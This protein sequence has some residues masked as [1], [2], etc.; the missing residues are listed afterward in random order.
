MEEKLSLSQRFWQL[1][2]IDAKEIRNVYYYSFF[3]G[4]TSLTLPLGIQAIINLIQIGRIN[5]AWIVMVIIVVLGFAV[6]GI[7]QIL[8][9]RITENIQQRIFTRAAFDFAYRVPRIKLEALFKTY[10]PELVNRFFDVVT[11]QKGMSK[12]LT[13]ISTSGVTVFL[14]LILLSLY[15]PFFIIFSFL[16]IVILYL[17]FKLMGKRGLLTSFE[18]STHKYK[19]VHWLEEVGRTSISF[20]MAGKTDYALERSNIHADDYLEAREKHFK[21]LVSHYSLLVI[22]KVLIVAGLLIIGGVLVMEQ[23]MNIGQ[24]VAAEIIIVMIIN[25]IEK[26]IRDI[27][28][29]YD[30]LTGI[31]K[32][33]QVTDLPL[34]NNEGLDL[35]LN[36][37]EGGLN[38]S[39]NDLSFMYPSTAIKT[40]SN[41]KLKVKSN[42]SVAIVGKISSG[43]STLMQ[44]IAGFYDVK[45]GNISYND[46]SLGSLNLETLRNVIG[47][48]LIQED[49]F[50]GTIIEN[51]KVGR[52][53]A[54]TQNVR[55]AIEKVGLTD[56][57][58][59]LPMGFN[60]MIL[61]NGQ[62]LPKNV[63]QKL[64]IARSIVDKPRLLLLEN[65]FERVTPE[66]KKTIMDFLFDKKN[67]WTIIFIT[68]DP[69]VMT[70]C[71][72]VVVMDKGT[73]K[74]Q[75]KYDQ[76]KH[77]LNDN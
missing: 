55:W 5:S 13:S 52:S 12:L 24:F 64:L 50:Y 20:R 53:D 16:L 39:I 46:L 56:F 54:S 45:Q 77:L 73:I 1:I 72:K 15:H 21:V 43:K 42:E 17:M 44:I 32:V 31:E 8:Q 40:L 19:L 35:G 11:I 25:S 37:A 4:L 67:N 47:T 60:T 41:V 48:N 51:I 6:K 22:F 63:V 9:L 28:T 34:E 74:Q 71:D 68:K 69:E 26:L 30:V 7:L 75:G 57:I 18:E 65:S 2:K 27:D 61:P 29:I 62:S 70:I 3:A 66:D 38:L 58:G 59:E 33:A 14:G 23:E 36:L 10:T 76:V 49:L